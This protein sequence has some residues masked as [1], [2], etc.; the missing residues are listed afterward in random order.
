MYDSSSKIPVKISS[1][2]V[3]RR[4]LFPALKVYFYEIV[5]VTVEDWWMFPI[6]NALEQTRDVREKQL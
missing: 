5:I 4:D 2:S 6:N 3:A 1:G